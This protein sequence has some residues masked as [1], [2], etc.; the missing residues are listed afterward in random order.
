MQT[1]SIENRAGFW[2]R[3]AAYALDRLLLWV[4]LLSVQIPALFSAGN[5]YNRT[6]FFTFTAADILRWVLISLY[7]VMLTALGG[8][9]LGKKAMGL[10]VVRSEDG[11]RL[12]FWT[13]LYRETIGRY[14][15]GILCIGYLL[16]AIDGEKRG[17]HD[18]ICDT[19]V[20]Y[21]QRPVPRKETD[22]SLPERVLTVVPVE[23]PIK[24]WYAPY[25][26]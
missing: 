14:L 2:V 12:P 10:Q 22:T 15:S 26:K 23:D 9:T 24:D 16:V 18:R 1:V 19:L 6:I 11:G 3:L 17:L 21:A 5:F 7:F 13:A 8:A 4:A 25:R 20:V